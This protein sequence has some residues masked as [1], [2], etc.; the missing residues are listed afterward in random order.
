MSNI[1]NMKTNFEKCS[2][3]VEFFAFLFSI[4]KPVFM[5]DNSTQ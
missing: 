2:L 1:L 4:L 5:D 3:N